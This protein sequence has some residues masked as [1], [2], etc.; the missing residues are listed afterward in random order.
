[1]NPKKEKNLGIIKNYHENIV[2][3]SLLFENIVDEN[4]SV[5]ILCQNAGKKDARRRKETSGLKQRE[6][7][8]SEIN[9]PII[10]RIPS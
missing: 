3:E 5:R 7:K 10:D 2:K 9:W 8:A 4:I 1:M 6:T